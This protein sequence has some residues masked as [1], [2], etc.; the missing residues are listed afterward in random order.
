MQTQVVNYASCT[1]SAV[2]H[3][4]FKSFLKTMNK[5]QII[6]NRGILSDNVPY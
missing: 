6:E 2:A 1:V 3:L 4:K 5:K